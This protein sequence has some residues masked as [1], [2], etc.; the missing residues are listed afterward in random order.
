MVTSATR[1]TNRKRTISQIIFLLLFGV[2]VYFGRI[3]LWFGVFLLVG[4]F[5][6]FI[7]GRV[8]CSSVC[9]MG[10]LMRVESWILHKIGLKR[11]FTPKWFTSTVWNIL[12]FVLFIG[13][14]VITRKRGISFPILPAMLGL[15]LIVSLF[16]EEALWHRRICPFGTIL[17]VTSRMAHH[18]MRV[19]GEHCIGCGACE[20]ICT[21][22]CIETSSIDDSKRIIIDHDCIGCRKCE[23]VCP[24]QAISYNRTD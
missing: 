7:W 19:E 8:Y 3:Q 6:S 10:T 17:S 14:M 5:G 1:K 20:R 23:E 16:F 13:S 18:G 22:H 12:F 15:S 9:P 2:L 11:F 24:T 21:M 4:V